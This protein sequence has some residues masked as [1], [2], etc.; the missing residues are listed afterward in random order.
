MY[1][2][3]IG[4]FTRVV[5]YQ[6]FLYQSCPVPG[7]PIP[8]LSSTRSSYTRVVQYQEF[9]Y[10]SCPVPGVP[11]P[12]LSSTRSSY[13]RVDKHHKIPIAV[14]TATPGVL[15]NEYSGQQLARE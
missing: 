7:V 13:T 4:S 15:P 11:I 5:Q 12:E 2:Y 8:E 9:L 10:Q 6:E 1:I 3:V 14:P